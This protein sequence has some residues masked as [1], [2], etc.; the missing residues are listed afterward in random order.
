VRAIFRHNALASWHCTPEAVT[1]VQ[2]RG[3]MQLVTFVL[4]GNMM[5][6]DR[7]MNSHSEERRKK[8]KK[9][10]KKKN[11]IL[12]SR[13]TNKMYRNRIV[14]SATTLNN[15]IIKC[16]SINVPVA[17]QMMGLPHC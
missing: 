3:T 12:E 10:K 7:S 4:S 8:K 2:P 13:E 6:N 16:M 11:K 14:N 15:N 17:L 5:P 9:K 1:Q